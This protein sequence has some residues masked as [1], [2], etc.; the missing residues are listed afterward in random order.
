[1][2]NRF[3][4]KAQSTLNRALTAARELGHTYVGSEHLL[5]LPGLGDG[6]RTVK[7]TALPMALLYRKFT[8]DYTCWMFS[9]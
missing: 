9:R 2:A 3:T 4:Q 7:G 6:L 5:L 8:K 1:M